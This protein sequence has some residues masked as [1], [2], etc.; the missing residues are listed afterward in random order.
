MDKDNPMDLIGI[1][2]VRESFF[3][4]SLFGAGITLFS[5]IAFDLT[6]DLPEQISKIIQEPL[7]I[8][9]FAL[10]SVIGLAVVTLVAS[11]KGE[12]AIKHPFVTDW[13]LA[14]SRAGLTAGSIVTGMLFGIGAALWLVTLGAK[15]SELA[16]H[17]IL[18]LGLSIFFLLFMT[19]LILLHLY[20]LFPWK[21]KVLFLDVA[22]IIYS[23]VVTI[24]LFSVSNYLGWQTVGI[25]FVVLTIFALVMKKM[26]TQ[27]TKG[28]NRKRR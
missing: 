10:F 6:E 28:A 15:N 13:V 11:I 27:K 18:F 1:R 4:F 24:A 5:G 22:S 9:T 26:K 16:N 8:N 25:L 2:S 19:P 12:S 21:E 20:I 7:S 14:V 23:V 17:A 3:V